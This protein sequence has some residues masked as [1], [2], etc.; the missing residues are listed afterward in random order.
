MRRVHRSFAER[1]RYMAIFK[2]REC[3]AVEFAPRQYAFH[4][5]PQCRCP[6]CGTLRVV[7]LRS[8]DRIDPMHQGLLNLLERMAGGRLHHCR[9][10]R[11]P[12][13][14]PQCDGE[15]GFRVRPCRRYQGSVQRVRLKDS[16]DSRA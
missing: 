15:T 13:K 16:R 5:G 14:N 10:C 8:P 2:C 1:F 4:F 7:R 9:Y 12:R 6:R 11:I 3:A